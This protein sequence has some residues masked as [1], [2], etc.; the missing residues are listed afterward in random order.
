MLSLWVLRLSPKQCQP[1]GLLHL[2]MSIDGG[3]NAGK[4]AL[5]NL[6]V[7]GQLLDGLD[8]LVGERVRLDAVLL[9]DVVRNDDGVEHGKA[10]AGV[11][12]AVVAVCV[13]AGQFLE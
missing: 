6:R 12:G 5:R 4:D 8:V 2:L 9:H 13:D 3:R 7:L 10:L 11:E 1:D